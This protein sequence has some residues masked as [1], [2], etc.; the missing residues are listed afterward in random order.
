MCAAASIVVVAT[1]AV[2]CPPA[3]GQEQETLFSALR[4][5]ENVAGLQL[6]P[7]AAAAVDEV[8]ADMNTRSTEY[9]FVRLPVAFEAIVGA[10]NAGQVREGATGQNVGNGIDQ[11]VFLGLFMRRQPKS[12]GNAQTVFTWLRAIHENQEF[13]DLR[14]Q[15]GI[16]VAGTVLQLGEVALHQEEKESHG[17]RREWV[18]W[19]ADDVV[20]TEVRLKASYGLS[21]NPTFQP[22]TGVEG[23]QLQGFRYVYFGTLA[24]ERVY[25]RE[26]GRS[27][28]PAADRRDLTLRVRTAGETD[29]DRWIDRIYNDPSNAVQLFF[30]TDRFDRRERP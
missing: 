23:G 9:E 22:A 16:D 11:V 1:F 4:L 17:V 8:I 24:S 18:E 3:S 30:R 14:V 26:A 29:L 6:G 2:T 28:I 15:Q 27:T 12:G 5:G 10:F 19:R 13:I 25:R 7:D 21:K 20:G